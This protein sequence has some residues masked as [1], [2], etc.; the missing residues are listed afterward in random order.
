LKRLLEN[1]KMGRTI[2]MELL[3]PIL[4]V[5]SPWTIGAVSIEKEVTE[6]S[7]IRDELSS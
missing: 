3:R 4:V 1:V 7:S 6:N 5:S 2:A